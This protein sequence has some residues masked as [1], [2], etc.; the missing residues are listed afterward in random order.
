MTEISERDNMWMSQLF[1]NACFSHEAGKIIGTR[2]DSGQHDFYG[3]EGSVLFVKSSVYDSHSATSDFLDD[4]I[5]IKWLGLGGD[6]GSIFD[7][8]ACSRPNRCFLPCGDGL[9]AGIRGAEIFSICSEW[10]A[11]AGSISWGLCAELEALRDQF[12]GTIV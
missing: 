4:F 6:S 5:A 11:A 9:W 8:Q 7:R 2:R 3:N 10:P 12:R 1:D